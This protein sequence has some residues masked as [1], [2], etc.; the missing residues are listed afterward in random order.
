[1]H[2]RA[3]LFWDKILLAFGP[4][5]CFR[6]VFYF[7]KKRSLIFIISFCLVCVM[8]FGFLFNPPERHKS[9]NVSDIVEEDEE[10]FLKDAGQ[11]WSFKQANLC[12]TSI[13]NDDES[14]YTK[15]GAMQGAFPMALHDDEERK[16]TC[17][18]AEPMKKDL[19]VGAFV[20]RQSPLCPQFYLL[21]QQDWEGRIV[22]DS[23]PV[24]SDNSVESCEISGPDLEASVDS[25]TEPESGPRNLQIV[26]QVETDEKNHDVILHSSSVLLEPFGSRTGP[27]SLPFPERRYHPQL[28]RLGSRLEV[29]DSNDTD[30]RSE[31]TFEKQFHQSNVVK[32]FIKLTSQNREM[33]EG[34]WSDRIMWEAESP[35]GKPR[36]IFDLQDE[37][38]LF[39]IMDDMD[40]KLVRLRAGAMIMT[41]PLKSSN[42][43]SLEL[44]GHGGQSGWRHVSNDKNYS[45]RKTSQQMKSNSKKRTT[46]AI[47]IYHSQPALMLQTMKLKLSK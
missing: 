8:I 29:D 23:S 26:P 44:P 36:L 16:D 14:E 38:M 32:D 27:S 45:N 20:G 40:G 3:F 30:G 22:W 31:Q 18:I 11:G 4:S 6:A 33:I 9:M 21:D 24:V 25:E 34:L 42:G 12:D 28:L 5:F 2:C 46:Q 7:D 35:V 13:S 19:T 17:L 39:E 10:A 47:K 43:D 1:M 41:H 15:F 37:Q